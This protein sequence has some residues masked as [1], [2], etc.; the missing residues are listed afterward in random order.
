MVFA[1]VPDLAE[2]VAAR[3][4]PATPASWGT[5]VTLVA[6]AGGAAGAVAA[7]VPR[8]ARPVLLNL[9]LRFKALVETG[10]IPTLTRNPAG[11]HRVISAA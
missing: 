7:A 1:A 4:R 2:Q 6:N 10:E 3:C 11:D 9:L 8:L 5:E